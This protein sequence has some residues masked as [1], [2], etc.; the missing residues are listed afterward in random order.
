MVLNLCS[1]TETVHIGC[2][3]KND[4][5]HEEQMCFYYCTVQSWHV[6]Y[7]IK[8]NNNFKRLT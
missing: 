4:L 1:E 2:L 7:V 8:Q 3:R 6:F 5:S